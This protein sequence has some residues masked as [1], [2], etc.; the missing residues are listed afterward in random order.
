MLFSVNIFVVNKSV[1][2]FCTGESHSTQEVERERNN[3]LKKQ[4]ENEMKQLEEEIAACKM[5]FCYNR[6]F[7]IK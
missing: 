5:F 3:S 1:L 2:W 6:N 7:M 4:I